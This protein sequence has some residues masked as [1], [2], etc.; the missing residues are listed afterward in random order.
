MLVT[1][2]VVP[3]IV[4]VAGGARSS[5][6]Q[7]PTSLCCAAIPGGPTETVTLPIWSSQSTMASSPISLTPSGS[8][9]CLFPGSDP[10]PHKLVEEMQSGIDVEM[11][12]LLG[13]NVSLLK[14]LESLNVVTSGGSRGGD[15]GVQVNTPFCLNSN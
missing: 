5:G 10:F 4:A 9:T 6:T 3:H 12:E 14:E 15:P 8:G 1:P 11:K 2:P 13:D 7:W